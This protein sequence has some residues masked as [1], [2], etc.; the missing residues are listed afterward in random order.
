VARG[1]IGKKTEK[2]GVLERETEETIV[3]RL[4]GDARCPAS[5]ADRKRQ[6]WNR[7]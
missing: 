2:Y 6:L 5:L 3:K 4:R 7:R 1:P